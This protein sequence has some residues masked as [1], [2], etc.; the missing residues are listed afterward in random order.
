M[1]DLEY[2][3]GE[4]YSVHP[5]FSMLVEGSH[6]C[7]KEW[8][9]VADLHNLTK[10][11]DNESWL[12]PVHKLTTRAIYANPIITAILLCICSYLTAASRVRRHRSSW[13]SWSRSAGSCRHSCHSTKSPSRNLT[14]SD[15]RSHSSTSNTR[16]SSTHSH[17][18]SHSR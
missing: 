3:K 16:N 12:Y 18:N 7:F 17:N 11:R 15:N 8:V 10:A 2:V 14:P 6:E 4:T 5:C 13:L 9:Q 1:C